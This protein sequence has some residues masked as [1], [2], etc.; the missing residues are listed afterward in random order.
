[1]GSENVDLITHTYLKNW[2]RS[3]RFNK[4]EE[5]MESVKIW[6]SSQVAAFFDTGIQKRIPQY[7]K[8]LKSCGDYVE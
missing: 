4:N 2:L 1:M 5:L 7:D 3:Q 8:C 6:R